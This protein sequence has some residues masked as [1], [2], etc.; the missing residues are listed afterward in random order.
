MISHDALA[1]S[2]T[3]LLTAASK[4]KVPGLI[5]HCEDYIGETLTPDTVAAMF[6]LAVQIKSDRLASCCS[7]FITAH[8]NCVLST[9][10]LHNLNS[11]TLKNLISRSVILAPTLLNPPTQNLNSSFEPSSAKPPYV[12]LSK[13]AESADEM[14]DPLGTSVE[15]G[16]EKEQGK[17]KEKEK[18]NVDE[19]MIGVPPQDLSGSPDDVV[20]KGVVADASSTAPAKLL[21]IFQMR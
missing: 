21:G 19:S 6:N 12:Q 4:L 1:T 13:L 18:E 7:D 11:D 20:D 8:I 15:Q 17:D 16:K 3:I 5:S 9:N 14:K 10:T 2:S